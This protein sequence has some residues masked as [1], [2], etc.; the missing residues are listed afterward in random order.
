MDVRLR[1]KS[2]PESGVRKKLGVRTKRLFLIS[3]MELHTSDHADGRPSYNP[4]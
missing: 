2:K 3:A 1:Q 4:L